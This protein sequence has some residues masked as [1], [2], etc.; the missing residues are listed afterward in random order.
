MASRI[1]IADD[2]RTV[3]R[4]VVQSLEAEGHEVIAVPDGD[5]AFER[6][7]ESAPDLVL[8]DV[9][10]P[11]LNGYQLAEAVGAEE[12]LRG[13][14]VLLL[15]GAFEPFDEGR[16]ESCG[17][18]GHLTKP[19]QSSTLIDSVREALGAQPPDSAAGA[20]PATEPRADREDPLGVLEAESPLREG[21]EA[22][23]G[24]AGGD[25]PLRWDDEP[26]ASGDS[27][28]AG[29]EGDEPPQ[30]SG[31]ALP[32]ESGFAV[33]PAGSPWREH[34]AG[35]A[36]REAAVSDE[37]LRRE[38][39]RRVQ[40]LAPDII[41]EVAW[42]VVPDLLERLLREATDRPPAPREGNGTGEERR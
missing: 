12:Q 10:M 11:G 16:A 28:T 29:T 36:D 35:T 7:R 38:I 23:P 39:A 14:P 34:S 32:G 42:E 5:E 25:E 3:R 21:S 6:I 9:L 30:E 41:R 27:S 1:L 2:S 15:S 24:A 22:A 31:V 17:A 8:A 33:V 19:F 20:D 26:S 40:Q 37:E 13:I 18:C 4:V